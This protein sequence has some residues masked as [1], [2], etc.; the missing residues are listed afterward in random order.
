MDES[1]I[2]QQLSEPDSEVSGLTV[3]EEVLMRI[4][5]IRKK[6]KGRATAYIYGLFYIL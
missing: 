5:E 2:L 1:N 3:H 4:A 6:S